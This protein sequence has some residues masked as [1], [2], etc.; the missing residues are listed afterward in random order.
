M[1]AFGDPYSRMVAWLK[2]ILPLTAL[3][4]LSTLF[5]MSRS[6]DPTLSITFSDP[7]I[8]DLAN[9]PRLGEPAFSGVTENGSAV[10]LAAKVALP[11][12]NNPDGILIEEINATFES[13]DGQVVDILAGNGT[14]NTASQKAYLRGG[15]SLATSLGYTVSTESIIADLATSDIRTTGPIRASGPLGTV[16]AGQMILRPENRDA[17]DSVEVVFR[18]GVRLVYDPKK[19]RE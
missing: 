12:A 4:I 1:P 7:E 18:D 3:A 15:V 19:K 6:V 8:R 9:Q 5:L 14:L 11:L 16:T 13:P 17:G 2:V 10:R